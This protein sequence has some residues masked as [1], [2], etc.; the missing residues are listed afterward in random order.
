MLSNFSFDLGTLLLATAFA[1]VMAILFFLKGKLT[2]TN[3]PTNLVGHI[4]RSFMRAITFA[5]VLFVTL[6]VISLFV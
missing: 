4:G 3:T 5:I 2:P 6:L 1:G